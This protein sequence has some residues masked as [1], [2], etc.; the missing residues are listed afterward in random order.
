MA[1]TLRAVSAGSYSWWLVATQTPCE[2]EH[3]FSKKAL[4]RV[5]PVLQPL[6]L[7]QPAKD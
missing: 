4:A 1:E 6:W 2:C 5:L 3:L 7:S